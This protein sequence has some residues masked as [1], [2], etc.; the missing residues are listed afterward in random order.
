MLVLCQSILQFSILRRRTYKQRKSVTKKPCMKN[1]NAI[2]C[3]IRHKRCEFC[4]FNGF[5]RP[6]NTIKY[7]PLDIDND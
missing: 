5:F 2:D 1:A 4:P 6:Q 7:T 3:A